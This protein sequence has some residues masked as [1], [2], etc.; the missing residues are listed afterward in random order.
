MTIAWVVANFLLVMNTST[1]SN[2][3]PAVATPKVGE[4]LYC[5]WGYDQTNVDWYEVLAVTKASIKIRKI[6]GRVIESGQGSDKVVPVPGSADPAAKVLT[7][8]VK[9]YDGRYNVTISSYSSAYLWDGKP[10][11]QTAAGYGH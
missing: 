1:A 10:Q 9:Q 8:R 5:S 7:K 3:S 4:I 6:S 2:P 11:W